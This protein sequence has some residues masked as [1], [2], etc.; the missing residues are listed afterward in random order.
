MEENNSYLIIGGDSF[1]GRALRDHIIKEKKPVFWTTKRKIASKNRFLDLASDRIVWKPPPEVKAAFFCA[2]VTSILECEKK[3]EETR[4]INVDNTLKIIRILNERSIPIVYLSSSLVFNGEDCYPDE[5][6]DTSPV[7]EYGYQKNLMEKE[8]INLN[9]AHT[10]VRLSKVISENFPLFEIWIKKLKQKKEIE[11]F[12]DYYF[13][14]VSVGYVARVLFDI[15]RGQK[16]GVWHIS[17][18][19]AVSYYEAALVIAEEIGV[20][21]RLVVEKSAREVLDNALLSQLTVLK[22][23]RLESCFGV[24]APEVMETIKKAVKS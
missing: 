8:L 14:P 16:G 11:A 5:S 18:N 7:T 13:S 6:A 19:R 17:G 15:A 1:I 4:K 10:I 3:P 9:P 23:S 22:C 20:S 2:A 24:S 21:S 12:G